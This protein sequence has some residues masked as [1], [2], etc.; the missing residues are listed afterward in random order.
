[1][2]KTTSINI[3]QH[4]STSININQLF[5]SPFSIFFSMF[6]EAPAGSMGFSAGFFSP[7]TVAQDS[8]RGPERIP[9]GH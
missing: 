1:M 8:R 4:Q 9:G 3:N 6:T 5:L 2:G 7:V